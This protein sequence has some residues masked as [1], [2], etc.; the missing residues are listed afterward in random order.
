M[1]VQPRPTAVMNPYKSEGKSRYGELGSSIGTGRSMHAICRR[2]SAATREQEGSIAIRQLYQ[3]YGVRTIINGCRTI[4]SS[5][6]RTIINGCRTIINR[7][8]TNNYQ[9]RQNEQLSGG[10]IKRT[11]D[12]RR[13]RRSNSVIIQCFS[14]L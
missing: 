10:K 9:Q 14:A 8:R 6:V 11:L 7:C 2:D 12:L 4:I 5:A 3:I 1:H 13:F